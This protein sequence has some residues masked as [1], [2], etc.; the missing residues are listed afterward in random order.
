MRGTTIIP[1]HSVMG[2]ALKVSAAPLGAQ[3]GP[4]WLGRGR[5]ESNSD[6]ATEAAVAWPRLWGW[7]ARN[8]QG[9]RERRRGTIPGSCLGFPGGTFNEQEKQEKT[10]RKGKH[11]FR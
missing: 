11:S 1:I 7:K 5:Q 10:I 9:G 2:A 3:R 6:R 8:R 4:C